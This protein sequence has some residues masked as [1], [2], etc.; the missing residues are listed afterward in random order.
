MFDPDLDKITPREYIVYACPVGALGTAIEEFMELAMNQT[1]RNG[2]HKSFP[3]VTLCQFFKVSLSRWVM[4]EWVYRIIMTT[5]HC[6][7]LLFSI[8]YNNN[9]LLFLFFSLSPLSQVED[10]LAPYVVHALKTSFMS[11][12]K[13]APSEVKLK[14]FTTQGY[15]GLFLDEDIATW[16]REFTKSFA[17]EVKKHGMN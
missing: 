8:C 13:D 17:T 11:I 14:R 16:F 7:F 5:Y 12:I 9:S 2:A 1:G 6:C 4:S 10:S 15:I 3:H